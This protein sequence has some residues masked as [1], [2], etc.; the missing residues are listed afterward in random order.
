MKLAIFLLFAVILL[1]AGC[2]SAPNKREGSGM[3]FS[4][5]EVIV[6]RHAAWRSKVFYLSQTTLSSNHHD[7]V[8]GSEYDELVAVAKVNDDALEYLITAFFNAKYDKS[9]AGLA[10]RYLGCV[11]V[12]SMGWERNFFPDAYDYEAMRRKLLR[13]VD[14]HDIAQSRLL[15]YRGLDR[16]SPPF[17]NDG[18]LKDVGVEEW[19]RTLSKEVVGAAE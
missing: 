13:V 7:F 11:I 1:Y 9:E 19:G 12:E 5:R 10:D 16:R 2:C 6:L 3:R 15:R 8:Y 18:D 14:Y 17:Y 4:P